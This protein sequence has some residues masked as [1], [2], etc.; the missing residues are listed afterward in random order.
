M[1]IS[2]LR[3]GLI[4][5]HDYHP[6]AET[7]AA[8]QFASPSARSRQGGRNDFLRLAIILNSRRH[9]L[10]VVVVVVI[11]IGTKIVATVCIRLVVLVVVT[12]EPL[13]DVLHSAD[14]RSESNSR[15][16]PRRSSTRHNENSCNGKNEVERS[17]DK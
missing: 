11:V 4:F 3:K 2:V 15:T 8:H 17:H 7:L 16:G 9:V 6:G 13:V 14:C 10:V 1:I 12:R 5:T